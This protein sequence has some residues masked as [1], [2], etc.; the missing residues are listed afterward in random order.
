MRKLL[1]LLFVLVL[2]GCG[3]PEP[4]RLYDVDF[5]PV[6]VDSSVNVDDFIYAINT[7]AVP[8][9]LGRRPGVVLEDSRIFYN[10][11]V[12][13]KIWL[14]FITQQILEVWDA[15][16][17]IVQI[18]EGYLERLNNDERLK[19]HMPNRHL[20]PMNID[21]TL[22]SESYMGKYVDPLYVNVI[23]LQDGMVW[24]YAYDVY[25]PN[26]D[27]WHQRVEP[28]HKAH[29]LAQ[30]RTVAEMPWVEKRGIEEKNKLIHRFTIAPK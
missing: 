10:N 24:Y 26:T 25:N 6:I 29:L 22:I 15:R 20:T 1:F 21:V 27:V 8:W 18:V 5:D 4:V 13:E 11:F 2:T 23:Y 7:Y 16:K 9:E 19:I 14:K 3:V 12:V 28:Y 30:A 17:L